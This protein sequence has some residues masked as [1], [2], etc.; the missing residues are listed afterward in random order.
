MNRTMNKILKSATLTVELAASR[1]GTPAPTLGVTM[2]RT[3]HH[4]HLAVALQLI[5]AELELA[6][7]TSETWPVTVETS[8]DYRGTI[9]LELVKGTAEEADRAMAVLKA[10]AQKV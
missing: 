4:R 9:T 5:A 10:V 7:P 1:Y 2:P 3:A 6:I 8:S